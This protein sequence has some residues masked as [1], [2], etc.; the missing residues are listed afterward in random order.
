MKRYLGEVG[1]DRFVR[2]LMA[3]RSLRGILSRQKRFLCGAVREGRVHAKLSSYGTETGRI[4]TS[5]PNLQGLD[6]KRPVWRPCIKDPK[7]ER[8]ILSADLD[9]IELRILA[10][11][12]GDEELLSVYRDGKEDLHTQTAKDAT[13]LEKVE[14]KSPERTMAKRV[15]FGIAYGASPY[16]IHRRLVEE[17]FEVT[18]EDIEA[19]FD[20][21][22]E[23]FPRVAA[24]QEEQGYEDDFDTVSLLGR[25]RTVSPVLCGRRQGWPNREERLN[26]TIQA[27]GADIL[28]KMLARLDAEEPP[29][30]R[31]LLPVHDEVVLEVAKGHEEEVSGRV[32]GVRRPGSARRP[33]R[34]SVL[35]DW[36]HRSRRPLRNRRN[37][38][39]RGKPRQCKPGYSRRDSHAL[40]EF[41]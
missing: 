2:T 14:K 15:N 17:G 13:G 21:F 29:Y 11:V 36:R 7:E 37:S 33:A 24:W 12:S 18:E 35:R 19:F 6:N 3:F 5:A 41:Q 10:R 40:P 34:A 30:A 25:H 31:L 39:A 28:K 23:R 20:V 4:T 9:Q 1:E 8:S 32:A 26:A 38:G 22:F 27:T 16:A